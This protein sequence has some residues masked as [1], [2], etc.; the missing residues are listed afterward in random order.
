MRKN[1]LRR[2]PRSA[3]DSP[4]LE[5]GEPF[6]FKALE[7]LVDGRDQ[8]SGMALAFAASHCSYDCSSGFS[9][10]ASSMLRDLT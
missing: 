3:V 10:R 8:L 4:R 1:F 9:S 6:V 2:P 5:R 7:R